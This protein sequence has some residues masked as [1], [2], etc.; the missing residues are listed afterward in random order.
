MQGQDWEPVVFKKTHEELVK[1]KRATQKKVKGDGGGNK[2]VNYIKT[3]EE[4][5]PIKKK[6]NKFSGK[7]IQKER[8]NKKIS[9]KVLASKCNI[10]ESILSDYES[11]K[12]A[13]PGN[14]KVIICK[15]LGITNLNKK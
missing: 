9:R 7:L 4:D 12:I 8:V 3:D 14:H 5:N 11:G 13:I 10:K 15:Y 1:E 6:V 2:S